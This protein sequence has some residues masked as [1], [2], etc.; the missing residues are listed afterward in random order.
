MGW[1]DRLVYYRDFAY[2]PRRLRMANGN[3]GQVPAA[4]FAELLSGPMIDIYVGEARRRWTLHRS[5]LCHHSELLEAELEGSADGGGRQDALELPAHD[6][7]GFELLV[8]WLYQGRLDDV[9]DLPDAAQK[10]E[11]AVRCHAL[12]LLCHRFDMPQLKNVAMD[13]F[14]KGLHEAELVPDP[15]EMD[16][17]YRKSPRGSPFRRLMVQIAA[18]QIMDPDS[19][20][21]TDTYRPCLEHNVDFAI[22]LINAIRHGTGGLLLADPTEKGDECEYHDHEDGPACNLKGKGKAKQARKAK[23]RNPSPSSAR[24]A[25]STSC[26]PPSH[27]RPLPPSPLLPSPPRPARPG[28]SGAGHLLRRL[29][30]PVTSTAGTSPETAV[31]S[32]PPSPDVTKDWA[33]LKRATTPEQPAAEQATAA[34][35]RPAPEELR[36]SSEGAF[37]PSQHERQG[38]GEPAV[39][40]F[41]SQSPPRRGLWQWAR[42]GTGRLNIIGRLPHP[43][44]KSPTSASKVEGVVLNGAHKSKETTESHDD[45]D[46]P[47]ATATEPDD[48]ERQEIAAA[49]KVEGLGISSFG[50]MISPS[51]FSQTRASSDDL[52]ANASE[53][54]GSPSPRVIGLEAWNNGDDTTPT[55][56][57]PASPTTPDTPTPPHRR[58]DSIMDIPKLRAN[59]NDAPKETTSDTVSQSLKENIAR[60]DS[61]FAKKNT[62]TPITPTT[63]QNPSSDTEQKR[64]SEPSKIRG[65]SAPGQRRVPTYKIAL[66]SSLLSPAM[67]STSAAH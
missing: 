62:G 37:H 59:H 40:D 45:F 51:D 64:S 43:E 41:T 56:S 22:E 21:D 28:S 6:P 1:H 4:T 32:H 36:Q 38:E 31:A 61:N 15:D 9:S 8:K 2:S 17:I 42:A 46:I 3:I 12:Y 7:A 10:Y 67:R 19:D 52:I 60:L 30:S 25:A 11:Y 54:T 23:A 49:A 24:S 66:T 33:K 20:R 48:Y 63:P 26:A 13:Q 39:T 58:S 55:G 53:T 34:T 18:R 44:W 57:K 35:L 47:S 27:S 29:T 16:D 14:R 50:T 65:N 5:L